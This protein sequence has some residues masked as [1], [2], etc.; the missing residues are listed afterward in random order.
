[1]SVW[2]V[3]EG[4]T[5]K[6]TLGAEVMMKSHAL[7]LYCS[8]KYRACA[9]LFRGCQISPDKGPLVFGQDGL[10]RRMAHGKLLT[11]NR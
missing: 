7:V 9:L 5:K 3:D 1:V 4:V 10:L 11:K 2:G 6:T 8:A